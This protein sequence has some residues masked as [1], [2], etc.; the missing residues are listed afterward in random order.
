MIYCKDYRH[1]EVKTVKLHLASCLPIRN[2]FPDIGVAS[3]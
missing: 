3:M 1:G 2:I